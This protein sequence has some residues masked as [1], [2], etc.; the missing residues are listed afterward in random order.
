MNE[1]ELN[2]LRND[3]NSIE[4]ASKKIEEV[5]FSVIHK[6][7]RYVNEDELNTIHNALCRIEEAIEHV[8]RVVLKENTES[9]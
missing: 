4:K 1:F 8:R 9:D 3:L 5:Y 2:V 7:S 6:K